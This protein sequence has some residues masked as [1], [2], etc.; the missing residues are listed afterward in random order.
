MYK[1]IFIVIAVIAAIGAY[2]FFQSPQN[3]PLEEEQVQPVS[4]VASEATSD[5]APVSVSQADDQAEYTEGR[6]YDVMSDAQPV[7]TGDKIEVLELFWYRCGH[8]RTLEKPLHAWL[9]NDKP[10]NAEYV[11]F[12][13]VFSARW[14]AG[15][16]AFY[17]FE[18]LGI[19]DTYHTKLFN[20]LHVEGKNIDTA[21]QLAQWVGAEGG[22]AQA[23]LDTYESFAVNNKVAHAITMSKRYGI[24]GV[25][26]VIVDGR[27]RTS[28]SQ[29]GNPA[30]L[31]ELINFLVEKAAAERG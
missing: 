4:V 9:Q 19:S 11:A 25:P 22:D 24:E 3:I 10:E 20:A 21:E 1:S 17:T 16:R 8:C 27:Y 13:A 12:P 31:F 5:S 23:I 14:E 30:A 7:S 29:A 18:A 2:F 28:V 15:A 26:A 6:H